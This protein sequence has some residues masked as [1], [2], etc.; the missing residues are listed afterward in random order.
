[1]AHCPSEKRCVEGAVNVCYNKPSSGTGLAHCPSEKRCVEGAV[2]VCYNKP[3]SGTELAHCPSE[4]RCVEGA[5]N[6]CYNKP[7]SGTELAHCPSEKRCVDGE[8]VRLLKRCDGVRDCGDGS[9]EFNCE[10]TGMF[11]ALYIAH[12]I[13]GNYHHFWFKIIIMF[14]VYNI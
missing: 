10:D 9:D 1:M 13:H 8:C 12:V 7:S 3:S 5:V 14:N 4:K 11:S 6:V 2:N